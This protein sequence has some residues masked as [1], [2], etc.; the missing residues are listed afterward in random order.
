MP[1]SLPNLYCTFA[2]VCDYLSAEGV[3]LRLD[4]HSQATGQT[5]TVTTAA[6][7][8]A[9]TLVIQALDDALPNGCVLNFDGGG[10][11]TPVQAILIA[12]GALGATSL[13]VLPLLSAVPAGA[14]ATD[15]GV[16]VSTNAR[17]AKGISYATAAIKRYCTN[18]YDDS[19]LV[20]ANSV[21]YWCSVI[22]SR[23]IAKRRAQGCPSSIESDYKE[24]MEELKKVQGRQLDIED[25]PTRDPGWASW[26]NV[27]IDQTFDVNR[28]RVEQST[29][30]PSKTQFAQLMDWWDYG[31]GWER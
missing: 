22:A 25:I 15:N 7:Q 10:L 5:I 17:V 23:W 16:N 18:R 24:T 1:L 26:V 30:D 4:D 6:A 29:S 31:A 20:Q 2:D 14:F 28:V 27:T 9:I 13:S 19:M 3:E 12:P 21:N 11:P 8:Q